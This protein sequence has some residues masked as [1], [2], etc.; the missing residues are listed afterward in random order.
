MENKE[1]ENSVK[2]EFPKSVKA[3]ISVII[4]HGL[5]LL[6]FVLLIN[7]TDIGDFKQVFSTLGAMMFLIKCMFGFYAICLIVWIL[8]LFVGN[9]N[10]NIYVFFVSNLVFGVCLLFIAF[11]PRLMV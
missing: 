4:A 1:I 3:I 10:S 2:D 11:I 8:F 6:L 9:K 7:S 5:F